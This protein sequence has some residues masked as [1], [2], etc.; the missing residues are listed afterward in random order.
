M[1]LQKNIPNKLSNPKFF[2]QKIVERN[3]CIIYQIRQMS[4]QYIISAIQI[5]HGKE[6]GKQSK[7]TNN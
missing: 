6:V 4:H 5:Y 7:V 3:N 1:K 2:R